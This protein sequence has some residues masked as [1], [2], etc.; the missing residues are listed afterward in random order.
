[1]LTGILQRQTSAENDEIAAAVVRLYAKRKLER[2]GVSEVSSRV[3]DVSGIESPVG[4][5]G[6]SSC[7]L[8]PMQTSTL[9]KCLS[10]GSHGAGYSRSLC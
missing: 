4:G 2:I 1:M 5:W 8:N 10:R 7:V 6:G 9:M 3:D